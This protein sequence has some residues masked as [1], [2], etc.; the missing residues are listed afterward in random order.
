MADEDS[1]RADIYVYSKLPLGRSRD[2]LEEDI[3]ALLGDEGECIGR[4]RGKPGWNVDFEIF[5]PDRLD[6]WMRRLVEFLREWGV[7]PDTYLVGW[8]GD[9]Q[10][11]RLDVFREEDRRTRSCT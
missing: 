11:G 7:P 3:E 4:G 10:R 2:D 8:L 9:E 6:F 5:D 1:R